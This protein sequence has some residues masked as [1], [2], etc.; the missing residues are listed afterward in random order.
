MTDEFDTFVKSHRQL[1]DYHCIVCGFA[2]SAL[3]QPDD[4]DGIVMC[5]KC[6]RNWEAT[7]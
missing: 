7:L 2:F 6:Y 5:E 1:V 4:T 3:T